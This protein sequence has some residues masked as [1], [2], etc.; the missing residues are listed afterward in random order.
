MEADFA[1]F[2]RRYLI[3]IAIFAI[4]S[5]VCSCGGGGGDSASTAATHTTSSSAGSGGSAS[6]AAPPT[7]IPTTIP[8]TPP[9]PHPTT[10]ASAGQVKLA[11]DPP[12]SATD[13]TGYII[14]YGVAPGAYSQYVDVGNTTNYSISNLISGKTYYFSVTSYNAARYQ[15]T[16]SNEVST[17]IAPS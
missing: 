17:L 16:Y 3:M 9:T 2:F 12:D 4:S 6:T 10:N 13:V 14:H 7:T 8:T 11:W 5:M 1:T 15:S